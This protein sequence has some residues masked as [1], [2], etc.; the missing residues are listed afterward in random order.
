MVSNGYNWRL[1]RRHKGLLALVLPGLAFFLLFNYLPMLG[2]VIAFKD[3]RLVDG[4]MGSAWSGLENFP[5]CLAMPT[6]PWR[7]AIRS[8]SAYCACASGGHRLWRVW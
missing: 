1:Y 6:S 3:F 2:L 8:P 7:G 5:H 4:L